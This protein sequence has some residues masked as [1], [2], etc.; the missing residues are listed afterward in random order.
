MFE[1][2]DI[3][4]VD[5]K[6][7]SGF[8]K[9]IA[10]IEQSLID[11]VAAPEQPR[12]ERNC[13]EGAQIIGTSQR[14]GVLLAFVKDN[15]IDATA[16]AGRLVAGFMSSMA[17]HEIVVRGE[18]QSRAQR[19]RSEQGRAPKGVRPIDYATNDHVIQDEAIAWRS[20]RTI[21]HSL[22]A[23]RSGR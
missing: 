9:L 17:H 2:N 12:L 13:S 19:Q 1:D 23:L 11:M 15:E 20:R 16:A 10:D 4:G 7:R 8:Q 14:N 21:W 5:H 6:K 3:S 22:E 18:C